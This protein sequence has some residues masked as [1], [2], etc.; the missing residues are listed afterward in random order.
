[1][2][3]FERGP[4]KVQSTFGI[5][6]SFARSQR[7]GIKRLR[8]AMAMLG[9]RLV[10]QCAQRVLGIGERV[11]PSPLRRQFI[12][13]PAGQRILRHPVEPG[14]FGK[15]FFSRLVTTWLSFISDSS[16]EAGRQ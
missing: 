13:Q 16:A 6:R 8:A 12:E 14:R 2:P 7:V 3:G 9:H 11:V 15:R 10:G 1:M 5:A 4:V